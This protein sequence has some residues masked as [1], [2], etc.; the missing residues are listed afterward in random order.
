MAWTTTSHNFNIWFWAKVTLFLW[1]K[2]KS[3]SMR[4]KSTSVA[5]VFWPLLKNINKRTSYQEMEIESTEGLDS[6]KYFYDM[7]KNVQEEFLRILSILE[8]TLG[9]L[10]IPRDF[11]GYLGILGDSWGFQ[12][13]L[14]FLW[15][16]AGIL[17]DFGGFS[18]FSQKVYEVSHVSNPSKLTP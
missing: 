12:G 3:F 16:S 4:K 7:S 14:G 18:S 10:R 1:W 6:S 17:G 13:I 5:T 8:D 11:L 15:D 9:F 2:V